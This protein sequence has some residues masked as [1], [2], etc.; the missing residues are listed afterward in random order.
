MWN[1]VEEK[2]GAEKV[3]PHP[4]FVYCCK[5]HPRM[6]TIIVSGCYDQVLRVWDLSHE[7]ESGQVCV[8]VGGS[9]GQLYFKD[10]LF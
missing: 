4:G 5:F 7:D 2:R 3:L 6:D 1:V 8:C 9:L 10:I